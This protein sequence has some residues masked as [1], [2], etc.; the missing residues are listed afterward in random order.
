MRITERQLRHIIREEVNRAIDKDSNPSDDEGTL[1]TDSAYVRTETSHRRR[2]RALRE[3]QGRGRR[4]PGTPG[5]VGGMSAS[6]AGDTDYT[7]RM[8][9]WLNDDGTVSIEVSESGPVGG[10]DM[11]AGVHSMQSPG[12]TVPGDARSVLAAIKRVIDNNKYSFKR[13]GV[14]TRNFKWAA[15]DAGGAPVARYGLSLAAASAAL[16]AAAI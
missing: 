1:V 3:A 12:I 8:D 6:I 11:R 9:V 10:M 2:A 4:G 14:P 13:H 15:V 7:D 5:W 16:D